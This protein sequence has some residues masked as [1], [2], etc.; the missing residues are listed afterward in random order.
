MKNVLAI[1]LL[2]SI[3]SACGAIGGGEQ[4]K[5]IT[6]SGTVVNAPAGLIVLEQPSKTAMTPIDTIVVNDDNTFSLNFTGEAGYYRMNFFNQRAATLI[7]D[8]DDIIINFDG[9]SNEQGIQPEGSREIAAIE[10]FFKQVNDTFGPREQQI[11]VDFQQAAQAGD[12]E[13]QDEI[14]AEYMELQDEKQAFSAELIRSQ[15][16]N[17]AA[18]QLLSNIDT[19]NY[20]DLKDSIATVLNTNYPGRYYIEDLVDQI[21]KA[22]TTA[23]GKMAPEI[24]LPN[25]EGDVVNLSSLQGQVVLVDFWAQWCKPCRQENPNVV[26]AYNKYKDKGF[27]VYGV[28]LDRTRDK[29]LQAIEEDGLTWTHVSDLKY[30]QSIA[31][32]TYGINAIPF[33]IL[34]DREGK[35]IAKNLRGKVLDKTLEDFFNEEGRM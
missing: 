35:I 20:L 12:V 2:G 22:K 3:L 8:Q 14:R 34:V 31:A 5:G 28:S 10:D 23:I 11:N 16:V 24:S 27:T 1:L 19:D 6:I 15:E 4:E 29:W 30:F 21:D 33:S 25:P 18:Y 13:K 9:A 7:L 26:A 17:L 32:E